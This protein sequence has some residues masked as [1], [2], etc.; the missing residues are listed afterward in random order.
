[1]PVVC[2]ISVFDTNN[3]TYIVAL[4]AL[5]SRLSLSVGWEI[6]PERGRKTVSFNP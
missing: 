3:K 5:V 2:Y 6:D 4:P 1:M